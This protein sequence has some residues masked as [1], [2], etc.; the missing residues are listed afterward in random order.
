MD[1][2]KVR[3]V[4]RGVAYSTSSSDPT[5]RIALSLRSPLFKT[6][7][8]GTAA[9]AVNALVWVTPVEVRARSTRGSAVN[10]SQRVTN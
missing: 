5:W 3:V 9:G 4:L 6:S 8:A 1:R 10:T 2:A 7:A